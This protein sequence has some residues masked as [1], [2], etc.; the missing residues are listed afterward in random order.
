MLFV[1]MLK[2][3][4]VRH[5]AI[6]NFL[7]S[8]LLVFFMHASADAFQVEVL[9]HEISPGEAFIIKVNGA[10]TSWLPTASLFGK[11]F[12]F[13]S[14]GEGCFITIGAVE[15]ETEP[16]VYAVN[17]RVGNEKKN[18][19]LV[20]K[21]TSFQTLRLTLPDDKVF[22]STENLCRVKRENEKLKSICQI[23]SDRRW[24]GSFI[25]PLEN[26]IS[27]VYGTKRIIN[28]KMISVHR[29]V[30]IKGQEGEEVKAS[31]SGKVVLA[32]DLFF[33]GSTIIIDHGQ[34]IYTIY[35]HLSKFNVK[36]PD[37]VSKGDIIGF[38]G[39]SGRSSGPH[40]HFGVKVLNINTNPV[41]FVEL[42]L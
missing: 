32:E 26:A 37:I 15:M 17:L 36:P 16:G 30:D 38:V 10:K 7:V 20:V 11:Q 19:N 8:A 2:V 29:G 28:D 5:N 39:L 1:K 34:G 6:L 40:L 33:G 13:S 31:N 3:V 24:E 27:T 42:D 25:L 22:L 41:S 21:H 4:M 35:M 18:L 14:C 9:P 23:V 12:Y